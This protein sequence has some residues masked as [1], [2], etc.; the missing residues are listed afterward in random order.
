MDPQ[1]GV[2]LQRHKQRR[3]ADKERKRAVRAC[4]GCRRLKEKCDGG[5]PCRRC[6]RLRRQCEFLTPTTRDEPAPESSTR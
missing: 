5:V 2:R 6:T 3:V 1:D 4:D